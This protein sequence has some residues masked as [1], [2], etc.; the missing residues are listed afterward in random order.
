MITDR[1]TFLRT[2]LLS[3]AAASPAHLI[4]QNRLPPPPR[5]SARACIV[6]DA[7]TGQALFQKSPDDRRPVASTQKLLT[8]LIAVESLDL[9]KVITVQEEE[10]KTEPHKLYLKTGEKMPFRSLLYAMLIESFN[11]AAHCVARQC[12]G[13]VGGFSLFMNRRAAQ[14]GMTNS[15]FVTPSGLPAEQQYSTARD[16][17]RLARAALY[18][19]TIRA[20]VGRNELTITRGDGRTKKL[21]TT[22]YLLRPNSSYY[23]PQCTGMKTGFTNAAGKC[24]IS[25]A[26]HRGRTV[27]CVLL[28]NF[29]KDKLAVTFRESRAMLQ[30]ALGLT[31]P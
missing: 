21:T 6:I 1:R 8:A 16:M 11:D 12:A 5:V 2:S 26:T 30:W 28:G 20:I 22:N 7:V 27:I 23:M 4:A 18:N 13:S 24:L 3:L 29:G 19:P 10:T 14:L 31:N 25:S 17:S 9:N 15:R